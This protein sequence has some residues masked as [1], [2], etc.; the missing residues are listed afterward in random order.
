MGRCRRHSGFIGLLRVRTGESRLRGAGACDDFDHHDWRE[1][2][3]RCP[4]AMHVSPRSEKAIVITVKCTLNGSSLRQAPYRVAPKT[5]L[6]TKLTDVM[7]TRDLQVLEKRSLHQKQISYPKAEFNMHLLAM[8]GFF[9]PVH[10]CPSS[11]R[12]F[13]HLSQLHAR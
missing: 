4:G 10:P 1:D 13:P 2:G 8:L 12:H 9:C 11:P 7:P 5:T 3:A 6:A